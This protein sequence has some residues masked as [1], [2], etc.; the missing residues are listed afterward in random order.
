MR[1]AVEQKAE[2]PEYAGAAHAVVSLDEAA[3]RDDGSETMRKSIRFLTMRLTSKL[4]MT[5]TISTGRSTNTLLKRRTASAKRR[6]R[7]GDSTPPRARSI[8]AASGC[9][10]PQG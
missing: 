1:Q 9:A 5:R 2:I 7:P 4:A 8:S 3:E 6:R 10:F